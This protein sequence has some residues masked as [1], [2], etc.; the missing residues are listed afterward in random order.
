MQA[1]KIYSM[2]ATIDNI[3]FSSSTRSRKY[4][5]PC[6]KRTENENGK[7]GAYWFSRLPWLRL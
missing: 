4:L 3:K 2:R 5:S 7:R 6:E 1:I